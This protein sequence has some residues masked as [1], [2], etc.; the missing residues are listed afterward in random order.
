MNA[1]VLDTL[2]RSAAVPSMP[3]VVLRFLEI[4]QDPEFDYADLVRV[5]SADPGTVSEVLR[6]ANI[7]A[8]SHHGVNV[9]RDGSS[10]EIL[11]KDPSQLTAAKWAVRSLRKVMHGDRVV[12]LDAKRTRQENRPARLVHRAFEVLQS[13]ESLKADGIQL[14]KDVPGK[15]IKRADAVLG[16]SLYGQWVWQQPAK[17]RYSADQLKHAEAW[18]TQE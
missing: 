12:W 15:K 1:R 3:Q 17:D 10:A 5:L 7:Y 9:R 14:T 8:D 11:F 6:L 13:F 4:M 2:K 16:H 18:A